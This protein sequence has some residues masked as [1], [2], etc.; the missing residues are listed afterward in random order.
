MDL[1]AYV[2]VVKCEYYGAHNGFREA[3]QNHF[4]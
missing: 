2:I 4:P 3:E 1:G